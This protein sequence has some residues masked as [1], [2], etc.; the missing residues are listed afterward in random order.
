M[1]HIGLEICEISV[2]NFEK[3]KRFC[4]DSETNHGRVESIKAI[5][6]GYNNYQLGTR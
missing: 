5:E 4:M 1:P 6:H 3:Q 2:E